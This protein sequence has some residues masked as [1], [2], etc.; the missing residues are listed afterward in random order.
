MP[1]FLSNAACLS[2]KAVIS[3]APTLGAGSFFTD[4]TASYASPK[5]FA[6]VHTSSSGKVL[7][8]A[9]GRCGGA[10]G[11]VGSWAIGGAAASMHIAVMGAGVAQ[12]QIVIAT[13]TGVPTGSAVDLVLTGH[14]NVGNLSGRVY[15]VQG[16]S[17]S[18][19][20][21]ASNRSTSGFITSLTATI[22]S[23]TGSGSLCVAVGGTVNGGCDPYTAAG[24]THDFSGES[25]TSDGGD[26]SAGF[27]YCTGGTAGSSLAFTPVGTVGDNMWAVG[28]LELL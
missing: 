1:S 18:V 25:G 28:L 24:W 14:S 8:M 3:G 26:T 22:A 2:K 15:D 4:S 6:G 7:I 5:T 16:W 27:F 13:A 19:G 9:I 23:L 20:A 11:V 12:S 10:T 17:G 21:L